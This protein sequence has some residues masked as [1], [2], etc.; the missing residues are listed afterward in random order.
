MGRE[1]QLTPSDSGRSGDVS[2]P[3]HRGGQQ[4]LGTGRRARGAAGAWM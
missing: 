4:Y 3:A 1:F 2:A